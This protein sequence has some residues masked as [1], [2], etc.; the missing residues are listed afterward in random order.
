MISS[1]TFETSTI[2]DVIQKASRIAPSRGAA[3]DKAAGIVL[4]FDPASPIPLAVVRVTNLDL[5]SIE[6]V[7]VMEWSGEPA[8]WRLPSLLLAQVIASLP[9]GSGKTLT[10][11]SEATENGYHVNLKSGNTKA[12]F[13]PIDVSYYPEW[14][15]FD[16]D[17]MFPAQ[18]L[19]GRIGQVEWAASGSD[20]KLA[21]VY[22][23]GTYAVATDTFKLV[24][25]PLSI[26]DLPRTVIV[27]AGLLGQALKQTGDISIRITNNMVLIMPDEHTQI[28][29]V[30]FDVKYPN[31]QKVMDF[32]FD[33]EIEL[34]RDALLENLQRVNAFALGE[35]G[36]AVQIYFGLEQ[37]A[38]YMTNEQM[39]TIGDILEIPGYA[40]HERFLMKFTP[41]N[42]I[43]ALQHSPN[44]KIKI[45]YRVG[46][47]KSILGI[48]GGSGYEAWLMSRDVGG[49]S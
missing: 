21:G 24:R 33:T 17:E 3:F 45:K 35:R 31:V 11:E 9:I 43:D 8:R 12:K 29:T 4:E 32:A 49:T 40:A 18:D 47:S 38:F 6:W 44:D 10:L 46:V 42:L 22:L 39:G 14:E 26:P 5:F 28:K 20:P 37:I 41:K 23:D 27:P 1:V 16:P 36:V 7:N 15:V 34:S 25:V 30:I 48:D 13:F 2:A 19:G